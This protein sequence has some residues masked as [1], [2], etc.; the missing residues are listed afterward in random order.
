MEQVKQDKLA[1]VI[2][3]DD[4]RQSIM[5]VGYNKWKQVQE[6]RQLWEYTDMLYWV[7]GEYGQLARFIIQASKYH[8]QVINGG[9]LQYY[10]NDY[11][12]NKWNR[13]GEIDNHLKMITL[14]ETLDLHNT[15]LG[16]KVHQ[17]MKDF[18]VSCDKQ[19]YYNEY[20]LEMLDDRYGK[21]SD[22][23]LSYLDNY[24]TTVLSNK[25]DMDMPKADTSEMKTSIATTVELYFSDLTEA[26]Q[27]EILAANHITDPAEA[28]WDDDML[29]L[30]II[31]FAKDE[32]ESG[33]LCDS[34]ES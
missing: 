15:I 26:K 21:V 2:G 25:V 12:S 1:A 7:E 22:Q 29:P 32:E 9:H 28:N 3:R 6:D 23:W 19:A 31:D 10:D 18:D 8:Q 4:I 34:I 24:L 30:A 14:M 5:D 33:L 17:I 20:D 27:N 13:Y 11:A 16:K